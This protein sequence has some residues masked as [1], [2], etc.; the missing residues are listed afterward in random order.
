MFETIVRNA[1][2]LCGSLFANVFQFDG[3]LLHF[4][5]S[6]NVE[7]GYV[8]LLQ[9]KYPMRPDPSQ[10]SGRVVLSRSVVRLEDA[11]GDPDYDH[12]F[13]VAMNWRRML[14]VPMLREGE[15][16]GVIVVGWAEPGPVSKRQEDLLKTFAD[17][18]VIAIENVR[19]FDE[20]QSRNRELNAALQQ[21]T[22]TAEVLKVISRSTFD[23][24]AVL[25]TLVES[26]I[27]LCEAYDAAILLKEGETLQFKSHHGPIPVD[28][29]GWPVSRSW[30]TGRAVLDG[31]PVHVHDLCAADEY[32]DGQMMALRMGFRTIVA[33][34][35]LRG[36][37]ALGALMIRRNEVN[38]FTDK[39]INLLMTF[40]DQAVIA[41]ENVRLF[42][43]VQ[44]R[45]RE[46]AQSV[47]ELRALGEV[48]QA[49]NSTL[50]LETVLNTI[51]AKAVQLSATDAGSIYVLNKANTKFRLRATYGMDEAMVAAI[52][53]RR[54]RPGETAIGQATDQ[55]QPVQIPD[56]QNSPQVLDIVVQAGFRAILVVPLLG[57][58]R[59]IGVLVIRRKSPGEF[60]QSTLELLQTFA[61]QSVL[62]IQNA[63]LFHEI[64]EK[65][66]ELELASRHKSQFL[67]NM[68]HELRTPLN[69]ILGYS[70]LILDDIYGAVPEKARAA[71]ERVQSNGKHLLGLIND[72]LDLAKIEAGR[73]TLSL[74][75]YSLDEVVASVAAS[76]EAMAAEKQL[77]FK[78]D[79]APN[80]PVGRGDE[81][82][83]TQVLL[84]L[85]SNA[86]KFTD[87][88]EVAIRACLSNGAFRVSVSDTGPGISA[89]D[90]A[91]LF[92]DFQ[93]ADSSSTRKKGGTGLGLAISKRFIDLHG[94][95]IWVDSAP[96]RGS[97]FSFELPVA[98]E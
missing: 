31:K 98:V 63:R 32:P 85:V 94:G 53:D 5:A 81:Q 90:Q 46:L 72:V 39:Q 27:R 19:L 36:Q 80:L 10:V 29:P 38:P 26:S 33:V 97:T 87:A 84:N 6:D 30:V 7:P 44:T 61:A 45:T 11:L 83:V 4:V 96:G 58:E 64:E 91:K 14:G 43:E 42:D 66:R 23:L 89:A 49:V 41:I 93:Q 76:M 2:S 78:L 40:A 17:Q 75:D 67:A 22:A 34:P 3:E 28:L 24:Q 57:P 60:P 12:Q 35:L 55:R 1:V 95:R 86:I 20:V 74:A 21:Q 48:S 70:E 13:P 82:R 62:A 54:I 73:L 8:E 56:V 50:D 65:S 37:E 51:V 25:D 88:G 92:Q 18:A 47:E 15:L 68:S 79:V 16:L 71:L 52:R 9:A 69:A 77:A 59:A